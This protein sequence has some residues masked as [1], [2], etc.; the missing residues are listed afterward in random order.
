MKEYRFLKNIKNLELLELYEVQPETLPR[1]LVMEY[2]PLHQALILAGSFDQ[3]AK[4]LLCHL[5]M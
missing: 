2:N 4:M 1:L 5:K 3:N